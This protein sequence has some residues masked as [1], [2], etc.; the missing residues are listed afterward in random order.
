MTPGNIQLT[1]R[2]TRR[3]GGTFRGRAPQM[4]ACAPQ[5]K[6]VPPQRGLCPEK[7]NKKWCYPPVFS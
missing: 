1:L 4:S 5:T 2:Q 3:H 7:I 6:F